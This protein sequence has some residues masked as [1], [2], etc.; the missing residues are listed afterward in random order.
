MSLQTR[1]STTVRQ[2]YGEFGCVAKLNICQQIRDAMTYLHGKNIVHGRLTSV[3]IYIEPNQCVKISLI[4][5]DEQPIASINSAHDDKVEFNASALNYLSPELIRTLRVIPRPPVSGSGTSGQT[6]AL[7]QINTDHLT[8]K[9]DIF[10]FGTIVYEMFHEQLPY[11]GVSA[12]E[13]IYRIGSGQL[14]DAANGCPA[15]VQQTISAC[16]SA[17]AEERP[18]FKH[19]RFDVD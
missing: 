4:D 17:N 12:A 15:L 11:R 9:S 3:N 8:K 6:K 2:Q 1:L 19:L 5:H 7:V 18:D 13:V 14:R 16:W 10:S